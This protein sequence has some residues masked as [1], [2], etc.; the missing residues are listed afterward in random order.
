[1]WVIVLKKVPR[2][3]QVTMKWG[4]EVVSIMPLLIVC[5][6]LRRAPFKTIIISGQRG[7]ACSITHAT[8]CYRGGDGFLLIS[9]HGCLHFM[10]CPD[11]VPNGWVAFTRVRSSQMSV[12]KESS[13][14]PQISCQNTSEPS[15]SSN[16]SEKHWVPSTGRVSATVE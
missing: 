9:W 15:P 16:V 3:T 6:S 1:M 11:Q 12:D 14:L 10:Q 8:P 7:V 13:P 2:T 4:D 5:Q